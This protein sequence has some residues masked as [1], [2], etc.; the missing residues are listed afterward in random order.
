MRY[1]GKIPIINKFIISDPEYEDN[2]QYTYSELNLKLSDYI[3]EIL[4][5]QN[6]DN[7]VKRSYKELDIIIKEKDE[8][9]KVK[10]NKFVYDSKD[11]LIRTPIMMKSDCVSMGIDE[12][13][14]EIRNAKREGKSPCSLKTASDGFFGSVIEGYFNNKISFIY[15]AGC[16]NDYAGYSEEDLINYL[17][18][19]LKIYDLQQVRELND[20]I[21]SH[22]DENNNFENLVEENNNEEVRLDM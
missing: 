20:D 10:G 22:L 17:K 15:I 4:I 11:I 18:R 8:T 3:V 21:N 2:S 16:I 7:E 12:F 19:Q 5:E 1:K 13:A 6:Y 14:E 9:I